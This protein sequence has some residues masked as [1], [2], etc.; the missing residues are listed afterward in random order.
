MTWAAVADLAAEPVAEP[1]AGRFADVPSARSVQAALAQ[2]D[3]PCVLRGLGAH[4]PAVQRWRFEDLAQKAPHLP[5]QLVAGNRERHA[6]R[7]VSATLGAY[8]QG[9]A[10]PAQAGAVPLY[11][12]EFDLLQALP[13]LRQDLRPAELW[14]R[15]GIVSSSTWVG[16]ALARTGLHHD[17]LDNLALL[18][19]GSKRF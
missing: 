18:V 7:F 4:W 15:R 11:L 5:V 8:L 16:P 19:T 13:E 10:Q 12:K 9:L 6:T 2:D 1:A 14:P 3:R 17:L